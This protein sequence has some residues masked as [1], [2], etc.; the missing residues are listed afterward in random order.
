MENI[1]ILHKNMWWVYYYFKMNCS[2]ISHFLDI[3]LILIA[4]KVN[5]DSYNNLPEP[6]FLHKVLSNFKHMK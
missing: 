6:K 4:N 2:Y 5:I 1:G 3:F